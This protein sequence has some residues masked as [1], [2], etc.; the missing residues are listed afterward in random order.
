[1]RFF[2]S[3]LILCICTANHSAYAQNTILTEIRDLSSEE[4]KVEGFKL[5]SDQTVKVEAVGFYSRKRDFIL[6]KAWILDAQTRDVVWE[7]EDA[8]SE[9]KG[10]RLVEY[11]DTLDLTKGAYEVYYAIFPFYSY[12]HKDSL[13]D[14]FGRIFNEIFDHEEY[15]DVHN[16][17]RK[18]LK[19]FKIV[20]RGK[21]KRFQDD[22]VKQ[23]HAAFNK[24][25]FVSMTALREDE[26]VQQG[27]VI[28]KPLEVQVYA[29]GEVR[30][31]GTFDYGW[32]LN[33]QTREKVWK[34]SYRDSN[35]AGGAKKNRM[36]NEVIL[37]DAGRYVAFFVTDDSHS[38]RGWNAAP[39]YDPMFWGLTLRVIEPAMKKYV[40]LFDYE[41][42]PAENVIVQ[43]TRLRD[44]EFESEGFTLKKPM[45]LRIYALGEG[46]RR[47][48]FDYGWIVDVKTHKRVWE[49][50]YFNTE[51]A[52]GSEKNR[53]VD[54][55][56]PFEK[57]SYMV[58]FVTDDSH[59]YWNW[60]TAPPFDQ[61]SW[62]ITLS[63][64]NKDFKADDVAKY[65][66]QQDKS[67]LAQL[68]RIQDHERERA[69]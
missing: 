46:R 13:G 64:V 9:R 1:M 59:S 4:I 15:D 23:L 40:K 27:F 24:N 38:Y 14:F 51:H 16:D 32:I 29:V 30:R 45:D 56:V 31:D 6:T 25:A 20:I 60:N 55:V 52:G 2:K 21:G 44:N 3:F 61:E 48:M 54:E 66:A 22:A 62:G 67:I 57:G 36:V 53:L 37:L 63:C 7:L 10:R 5:N 42:R 11:E 17:F 39:P 43:L 65:E 12:W 33:T 47:E 49:M 8:D 68:V 50:D 34:M 28:E 19:S 69:R 26:Y 18:E 41:D 35:H 58:Y